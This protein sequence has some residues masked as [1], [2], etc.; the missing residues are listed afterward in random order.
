MT[1]CDV[2]SLRSFL[3][4]RPNLCSTRSS[5]IRR[6]GSTRM[7]SRPTYV[8]G[9]VRLVDAGTDGMRHV[10]PPRTSLPHSGHCERARG[11][12]TR[13]HGP[14]SAPTGMKKRQLL[15]PRRSAAASTAGA[16]VAFAPERRW[17]SSGFC[18]R[19]RAQTPLVHVKRKRERMRH[20]WSSFAK[21]VASASSWW[22]GDGFLSS[23]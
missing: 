8:A 10:W 23:V 19:S 17:V 3:R 15:T 2:H 20:V 21:L 12:H 18:P 4:F 22:L 7:P 1:R 16:A 6:P 13:S 5:F 11:R 14:P 9:D